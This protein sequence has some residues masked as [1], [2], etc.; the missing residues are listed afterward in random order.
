MTVMDQ[1]GQ[2]DGE[3]LIARTQLGLFD[4][5]SSMA[6]MIQVQWPHNKGKHED[7]GD[8]DKEDSH[9]T[10]KSVMVALRNIGQRDHMLIFFDF[11][12]DGNCH[13]VAQR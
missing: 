11:H 12:N 5:I 7:D 13:D 1:S 3:G 10:H 2:I 8:D 4:G 9:V 6:T